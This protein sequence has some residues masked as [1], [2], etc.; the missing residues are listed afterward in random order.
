MK[1]LDV[2]LQ[3]GMLVYG[4]EHGV[5]SA[6]LGFRASSITR[7]LSARSVSSAP[8]TFRVDDEGEIG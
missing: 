5:A 3:R 2:L 8:V 6:S 7:P 1:H 4:P